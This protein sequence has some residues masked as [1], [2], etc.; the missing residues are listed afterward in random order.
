MK[1][2]EKSFVEL[3]TDIA[4]LKYVELHCYQH[5]ETCPINKT[6]SK[7]HQRLDNENNQKIIEKSRISKFQ[8]LKSNGRM[9]YLS[10]AYF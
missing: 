1:I 10:A 6:F 7:F 5:S 4:V 9:I 2:G 8:Q 3:V